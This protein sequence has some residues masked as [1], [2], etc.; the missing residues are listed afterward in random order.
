MLR[1]GDFVMLPLWIVRGRVKG[2]H[3]RDGVP[4]LAILA[5][6]CADFV[7]TA[8]L[9]S[10]GACSR[11]RAAAFHFG[12]P[13]GR[14]FPRGFDLSRGIDSPPLSVSVFDFPV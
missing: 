8:A 5:G 2:M 9:F 7:E 1:L 4:L 10:S 13:V 11:R 14:G 3:A 12:L 6:T